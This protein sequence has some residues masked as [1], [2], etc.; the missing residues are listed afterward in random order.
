MIL[1]ELL[2]KIG[3]DVDI[4]TLKALD[5]RLEEIGVTAT[6]FVE[7]VSSGFDQ[8]TDK[9][10]NLEESAKQ[11]KESLTQALDPDTFNEIFGHLGEN[12]QAVSAQIDNAIN[13][14]IRLGDE[15]VKG[16]PDALKS[17]IDKAEAF[18]QLADGLGE[19][20]NAEFGEITQGVKQAA[21]HFSEALTKAEKETKQAGQAVENLGKS[22]NKATGELKQQS[23]IAQKLSQANKELSQSA[24]QATQKLS[25]FVLASVGLDKVKAKFD[26][27]KNSINS[28]PKALGAFAGILGVAIGGLSLFVSKTLGGLDSLH[29]LSNVTGEATDYIYQLGKVAQTSGSSVEAA[30]SS[31]KGLS[32]V[33]G[34]AA[35]G[36]GRG[37]KAFELYGLSARNAKGE[38]KKTSE[39][40]E[41]IRAKMVGL[42]Q[43]E[44]IA[45]LS[46]L[47]I[48]GSMIQ[49][50]MKSSKEFRE[51]IDRARRMTL[52]VG[53]PEQAK[54]AADFN[55]ALANLGKMT[56]SVAEVFALQ[57]APAIT[58]IIGIFEEWFIANADLIQGG[59][60]WLGGA[61]AFVIDIIANFAEAIDYVISN[62]VG[63]QTA[64]WIVGLAMAWF[65]RT[66]IMGLI[67]SLGR[68]A[69]AWLTNPVGLFI[70]AI[71]AAALV[72]EDFITWL[73]G[74][75]S[76][77]GDYYEMIRD[78]WNDAVASL[79][80]AIENIKQ[81]FSDA[82]DDVLAKWNSFLDAFS[83]DPIGTLFGLVFDFVT[84]PFKSAFEL[85]IS[86]WN[87]FTGGDLDVGI[88]ERGFSSV[89]DWVSQPFQAG[90][91]LVR[92]WYDKYIK[93]IIDT[94]SNLSFDGVVGSVKGF[95]GFGDKK[96]ASPSV[97]A[98]TGAVHNSSSNSMHNSHN[99]TMVNISMNGTGNSRADAAAVADFVG[100]A[101][102]NTASPTTL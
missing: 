61:I 68:L 101:V 7:Q 28:V 96:A 64:F 32:Q 72:I 75:E 67:K 47:G 88:I 92:G 17:Y 8:F 45:M 20:F 53:T 14:L 37:A 77:L 49:V 78:G 26:S 16:N 51:E 36:K 80:Q 65:S 56:K 58:R 62:T 99:K 69:I 30:E 63:W 86:L 84:L 50:L 95:F 74:G 73:N 93:P 43:Q 57:L 52:G 83:V 76:A 23:T 54:A 38:I 11:G 60:E 15:A 27:L 35:T 90:F 59:I 39:V 94:I 70:T 97:T 29:Q 44:K 102:S 33:I 3:V 5:K 85:V 71:I 48:D 25:S 31:V 98:K 18:S 46:K 12:A 89:K 22:A 81:W 9:L 87:A 6:D 21:D 79:E 82:W 2:M 40:L 55:D 10:N 34:E 91:D 4:D 24:E 41:E 1:D 42:S 13:D 66:A 100:R 19:K